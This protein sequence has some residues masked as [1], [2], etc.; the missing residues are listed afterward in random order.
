MVASV[1]DEAVMLRTLD[2]TQEHMPGA[3]EGKVVG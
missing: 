1:P 3:V 2:I